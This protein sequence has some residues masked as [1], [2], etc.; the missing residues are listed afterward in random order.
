MGNNNTRFYKYT[1]MHI[2]SLKKQRIHV[3]RDRWWS[4]FA[5]SEFYWLQNFIHI[6]SMVW[7]RKLGTASCR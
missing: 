6:Y 2:I 7:M 4:S 3:E 1:Q 5:M